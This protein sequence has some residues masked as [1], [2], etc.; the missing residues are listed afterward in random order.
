M[1]NMNDLTTFRRRVS[2]QMLV[3]PNLGTLKVEKLF[4]FKSKMSAP[5]PN[6]SDII[7]ANIDV[8]DV[9]R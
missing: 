5:M 6:L 2:D 4:L 3:D 7:D 1:K 8:L 9:D